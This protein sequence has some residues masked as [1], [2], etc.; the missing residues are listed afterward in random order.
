MNPEITPHCHSPRGV[1]RLPTDYGKLARTGY[2]ADV[3]GET[4]EIYDRIGKRLKELREA[5]G[6]SLAWVAREMTL[7]GEKVSKQ[8]VYM[9][10]TGTKGVPLHRIELFAQVVGASFFAVVAPP[11]EHVY[12]L[13]ETTAAAVDALEQV[14]PE[15]REALLQVCQNAAFMDATQAKTMAQMTAIWRQQKEAAEGAGPRPA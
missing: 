3:N 11:G 12:S 14:S 2:K 9:M 4:I 7:R 10:E 1:N 13:D 6:V 15:I 5:R 8:W